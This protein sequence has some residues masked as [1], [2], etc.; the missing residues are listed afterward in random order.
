MSAAQ[1]TDLRPAEESVPLGLVRLVGAPGDGRG[2]L[3]TVG[4]EVVGVDEVAHEDDQ[5]GLAADQ[6]VQRRRAVVRATE[7][8]HQAATNA[9]AAHNQQL[10]FCLN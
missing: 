9:T 10:S 7:I 4:A 6:M 8:R 5:V 2:V 1:L 3:G